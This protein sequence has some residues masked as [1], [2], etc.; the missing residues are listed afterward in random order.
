LSVSRISGRFFV[1]LAVKD[2]ANTVARQKGLTIGDTVG[3]DYVV[4]D[5]LKPGDHLIVSGTQFLQD[6][7]PVAEQIQD[8]AASPSD[9]PEKGAGR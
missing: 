7:M 9:K 2:G 4:L 1:F 5:G 6:G 8:A 3:N